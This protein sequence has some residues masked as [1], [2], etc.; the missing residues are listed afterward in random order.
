M[1]GKKENY[2][3]FCFGMGVFRKKPISALISPYISDITLSFIVKFSKQFLIQYFTGCDN[4]TRPLNYSHTADE[5]G[6]SQRSSQLKIME[7]VT[8]GLFII[9]SFNFSTA[10]SLNFTLLANKR[11]A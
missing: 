8:P 4:P 9:N 10:S 6:I 1:T 2:K 5:E 11:T 7:L 3:S